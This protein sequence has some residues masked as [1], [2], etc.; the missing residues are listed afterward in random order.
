MGNVFD[1]RHN[2]QMPQSGFWDTFFPVNGVPLTRYAGTESVAWLGSDTPENLQKNQDRNN[3]DNVP[4]EYR[5]NKHGYRCEAFSERKSLNVICIGCSWTMGV[6]LPQDLTYPFSLCNKIGKIL[7][8]EIANWNMGC[9][10]KGNDYVARTLLFSLDYLNPDLVLV[11]LTAAGRKEFFSI[12][13]E[14]YD[15][16]G[17][18]KENKDTPPIKAD[19]EKRWSGLASNYHLASNWASSL[20]LIKQALDLRKVPYVISAVNQDFFKSMDTK[21]GIEDSRHIYDVW[22]GIDLA[23]DGLHMGP[24]TNEMAALALYRAVMSLFGD[25]LEDKIRK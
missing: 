22:H 25:A 19:L 6:G 11:N 17:H 2:V 16:M 15:L 21:L 10:A 13:G 1:H 4:I 12:D 23:R 3:W 24:K 9:G 8:T 18:F 7:G 14:C 20:H 5:F